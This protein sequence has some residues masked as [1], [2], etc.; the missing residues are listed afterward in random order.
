MAQTGNCHMYSSSSVMTM[1]TGPDG[2]PQVYQATSS[3]TGVPGGVRETR[4]TMSDSM[5]GRR[6]MAIGHHIG[7]RSH[8]I[9]REHSKDNMEER[10]EFINLEEGE[11]ERE[12]EREREKRVCVF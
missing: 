11:R 1:T 6:Q 5:T 10:Q 9:E 7:E 2:K 12:R 8:I 3:S 4:R